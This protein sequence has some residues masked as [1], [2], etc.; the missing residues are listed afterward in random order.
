MQLTK[1]IKAKQTVNA[2]A[3]ARG[4]SLVELMVAMVLGLIVIG[5]V[6]ALVLSMIRANNQTLAA[7][8]LTQELRATLAVVANDLKRARSVAD[9]LTAATRTTGSEVYSV[10]TATAGC[11]RYAYEG[12][13]DGD[14]RV[15]RRDSTTN[16]LVL[17][18]ETTRAAATCTSTGEKL[19]SDQVTITTFMITPTTTSTTETTA[20]QFDITITGKLASGN[21]AITRTMRQTIYVRSLSGT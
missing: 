2:R 12:G 13:L 18:A 21:D 4:F 6:I 20:R 9:P 10:D 7:T 19:G 16:R 3:H 17:V 14:Y 5:A 8:R 15:I 11:I 1:T